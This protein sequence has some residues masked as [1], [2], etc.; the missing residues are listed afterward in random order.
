MNSYDLPRLIRDRSPIDQSYVEFLRVPALSGGLYFLPAG[1]IDLQQPHNEDEVYY[2][3]RGRGQIE[4]AGEKQTVEAGT[5]VY[6]PAHVPHRF[7][8][9]IED[10]AILVLFAPAETQPSNA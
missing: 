10:L 2:V 9:I 1:G 3:V 4:G 7:H 8:T 6:V 5:L